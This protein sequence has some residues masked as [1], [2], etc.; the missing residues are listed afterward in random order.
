MIDTSYTAAQAESIKQNCAKGGVIVVT[1]TPGSGKTQLLYRL[2]RLLEN[3]GLYAVCQSLC[4]EKHKVSLRSL[5]QAI[6]YDLAPDWKTVK[7]PRDVEKL[8]QCFARVIRDAASLVVLLVD[9]AHELPAETIRGLPHLFEL[10]GDC[11][12]TVVLIV[13]A[14]HE[15]VFDDLKVPILRVLVWQNCW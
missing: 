15:P 2:K 6:S 7:I 3:D 14:D 9:D 8:E 11:V 12:L 13:D 5:M 4:A 1:G 10:A